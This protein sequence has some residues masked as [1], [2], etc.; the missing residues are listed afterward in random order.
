[1][2][3]KSLY[4]LLFVAWAGS[5]IGKFTGW[6]LYLIMTFTYNGQSARLVVM[7]NIYMPLMNQMST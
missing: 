7:M 4:V 2:E 3:Y 6:L 5:T 1:M